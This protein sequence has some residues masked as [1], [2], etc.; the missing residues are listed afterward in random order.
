MTS[1]LLRHRAVFESGRRR[2]PVGRVPRSIRAPQSLSFHAA[3]A[4]TM[5]LVLTGRLHDALAYGVFPVGKIF[6]LSGVLVLLLGGGVHR[7][8]G[9][10]Q[11]IP[12]RAF[13]ALSAAI[14]ASVPFS[15]LRS[16]SFEALISWYTIAVPIVL[17]VATSIRSVSD[18]ERLLR[19]LVLVVVCSGGLV[20]AGQGV[21]VETVDG[22][23]MTLAGSYDPNDFANVVAGCSAACLWALRDRSRVWRLLGVAGLVLAPMLIAK[24][25]SRGGFLAFTLL[26]AGAA[27]F[28]PRAVPRWLRIALIPAALV[29]LSFAP[30]ELTTRLSTLNNV[31]SDYNFTDPGGRIQVWKR[32]LGYIASRPITGVGA[33]AFI[34]A[35]GNYAVEHGFYAGFKWTAAHNILIECAAEL[36]LPGLVALLFAMLSIVRLWSTLRKIRVGDDEVRRLE[37]AVEAIALI[38]LTFLAS[39]MFVSALWNP[40]VQMLIALSI[41]AHMVVRDWRLDRRLVPVG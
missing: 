15:F 30:S 21:V 1:P 2:W 10:W 9:L 36:G 25:A 7:V 19:A 16:L 34:I 41:G 5:M 17:I 18:L 24:T 13:A 11:T 35:D 8:G 14:F 4:A 22:P 32:G 29:G 6:I 38:T 31:T 20:L 33:K 37:R 26:L 39:A 12:M 23:R 40:L 28:L 3:L 27:V